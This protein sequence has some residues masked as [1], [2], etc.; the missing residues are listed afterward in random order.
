MRIS[1]IRTRVF[2]KPLDGSTRNAKHRWTVK[3]SLLVFVETDDGR[4]GVGEA[5]VDA[6]DPGSLV[7]FIESDLTPVLIG[8]SALEPERHFKRAIE[9][10]TVSV[11]RSQTWACMSAI[12][13]ALWDL[14]AQAAG[15]PL[16]RLLGGADPCVAPYASAGLYKLGPV[17]RRVRERVCRPRAARFPRGE[18]QGWR[19]PA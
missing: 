2:E 3:R 6:G 9:L 17:D 19:C 4:I 7:A 10:A 15:E 12:D 11:R 16:W 8:E 1:S 18:D 14:K 13:I 5:W